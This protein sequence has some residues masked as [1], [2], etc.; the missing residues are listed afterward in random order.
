MLI[1]GMSRRTENVKRG[2]RSARAGVPC[3]HRVRLTFSLCVAPTA[4]AWG[5]PVPRAGE[6]P[7]L[8]AGPPVAPRA[9]RP[10][11]VPCPWA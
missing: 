6:P 10:P 4:K 2:T 3:R 11:R 5:P 9:W 7:E 8:R 1:T